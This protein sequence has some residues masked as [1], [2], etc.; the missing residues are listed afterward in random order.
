MD[1]PS[2]KQLAENNQTA[3]SARKRANKIKALIKKDIQSGEIDKVRSVFMRYDFSDDLLIKEYGALATTSKRLTQKQKDRMYEVSLEIAMPYGLKNGLW[4][5]NL[6]GR[7]YYQTLGK[8]RQD[9]D[10]EYSCKTSLEFMLADRIVASYWRA[11]NCNMLFNSFTEL[12][13]GHCSFNQIKINLL[14][15]L[16]KGMELADR[17]LNAD[18]VLLKELKQPALRVNVKTNTA[19]VSQNQQFNIN[20][21]NENNSNE[22]IESK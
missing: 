10:E 9:I 20:P 19:F 3:K 22:N 4:I 6:N 18:I 16:N 5:K 21:P 15:E 17:Q 7:K 2:Q 14:K 12:E 11:M 8:M 1:K 13:N